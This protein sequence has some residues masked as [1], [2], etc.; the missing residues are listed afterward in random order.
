[1]VGIASTNEGFAG[2]T[3]FVLISHEHLN[4]LL[5]PLDE[6]KVLVVPFTRLH[7]L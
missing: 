3:N 2:R 6:K 7:D 4:A 1:M 5:V